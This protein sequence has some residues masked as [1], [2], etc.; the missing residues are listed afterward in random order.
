MSDYLQRLADV[1]K[2]GATSVKD[3]A[4]KQWGEGEPYRSGMKGLLGGDLSGVKE[5]IASLGNFP[6]TSNNLPPNLNDAGVQ[7]AMNFSPMMMGTFAGVGAKTAD[8]LKLQQAKSM[9]AKGASDEAAW[10]ATGWTHGFADGKPRFEISDHNILSNPTKSNDLG[11]FSLEDV[12]KNNN[13]L[14][15]YPQLR[16]IEVKTD[17]STYFSPQSNQIG[18][19]NFTKKSQLNNHYQHQENRIYKIAD[20]LESEGINSPNAEK[21]LQSMLDGIEPK[22][23]SSVDGYVDKTSFAPSSLLHEQQHAIQSLEG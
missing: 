5:Q 20:K 2:S 8:M 6:R 18:S 23:G 3:A 19:S 14:D 15:A 7:T 22:A 13:S 17:G 16:N 4:V 12:L 9:M 21:R 11:N 10:K 1:L